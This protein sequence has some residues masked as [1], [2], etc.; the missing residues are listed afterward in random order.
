MR[1]R[2]VAA[3]AVCVVLSGC[4]GD[5]CGAGTDDAP[6]HIEDTYRGS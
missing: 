3:V 2:W 4:A 5:G 1:S 6:E